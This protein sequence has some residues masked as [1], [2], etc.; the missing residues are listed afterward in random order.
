MEY[1]RIV[2]LAHHAALVLWGRAWDRLQESPGNE[3][4]IARE[5]RAKQELEEIGSI[6]FDLVFDL[7]AE[8]EHN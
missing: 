1:K 3:I 5:K 7:E 4:E 6:L 8:T 2:E